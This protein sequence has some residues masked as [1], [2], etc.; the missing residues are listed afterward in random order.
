M[1]AKVR[2]L[3]KRLPNR[4]D[5]R[6]A[7]Q[8]FQFG[9]VAQG[10]NALAQGVGDI[11]EA[12]FK[13]VEN[14]FAQGLLAAFLAA[15]EFDAGDIISYCSNPATEIGEVRCHR[16]QP[17]QPLQHGLAPD[18]QHFLAQFIG[19][20]SKAGCQ[21]LQGGSARGFHPARSPAFDVGLRRDAGG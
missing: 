10:R 8:A 21:N 5:G 13:H 11:A 19:N 15:Q 18:G 6:L 2:S 7:V 12:G 14:I 20:L 3:A 17:R 1:A 9:L 16:G 4:G